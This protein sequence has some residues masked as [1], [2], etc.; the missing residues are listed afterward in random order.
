M[1]VGG[2]FYNVFEVGNQA[3]GGTEVMDIGVIKFPGVPIP[4][5]QY[6]IAPS[7]R[8]L[9]HSPTSP[10]GSPRRRFRQGVRGALHGGDDDAGQG[11]G[12]GGSPRPPETLAAT[13]A[14]LYRKMK[15]PG[16]EQHF[17]T[18]LYGVLDPARGEITLASA[19]RRRRSTGRRTEN[20]AISA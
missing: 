17:A 11:A 13:N 6:S 15:Q 16:A 8:P 14:R 7:L 2:D 1:E 18:A 12:A 20:R 4:T 9:P 3:N 5:L 10:R 19:G